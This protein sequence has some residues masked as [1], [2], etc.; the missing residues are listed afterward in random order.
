M[1]ETVTM[2]T[3]WS[4]KSLGLVDAEWFDELKSRLLQIDEDDDDELMY[5]TVRISQFTCRT[6]YINNISSGNKDKLN[7]VLET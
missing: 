6:K 3:A 4:P 1:K 2:D 5:N 7:A